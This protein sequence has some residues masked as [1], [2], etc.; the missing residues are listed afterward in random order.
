MNNF[1]KIVSFVILVKYFNNSYFS[2]FCIFYDKI[3]EE[4]RSIFKILTD[5]P[6]GRTPLGRP[7]NQWEDNI[8]RAR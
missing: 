5:I 6:T 2:L 1:S 3:M 7:R 8:M 4:G